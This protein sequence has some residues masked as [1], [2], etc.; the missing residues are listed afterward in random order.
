MQFVFAEC[1]FLGRTEDESLG[2][3]WK[4]VPEFLRCRGVNGPL[5]QTHMKSTSMEISIN[6]INMTIDVIS[7]IHVGET[8]LQL[9]PVNRTYRGRMLLESWALA[10]AFVALD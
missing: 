4:F 8:I 9:M 6:N 3:F 2:F 1:R 5:L 7:C 10:C